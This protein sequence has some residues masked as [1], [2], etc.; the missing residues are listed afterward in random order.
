MKTIFYKR[1]VFVISAIIIAA[2]TRLL[3]HLP[4][5]TPVAAM[6]L[7]GGATLNDK[8][9]AFITPIIAMLVS[10]LL[11]ELVFGYGFHNTMLFV[12]AS[13]GLIT[14]LGTYLQNKIKFSS[15]AIASLASSLIFFLVTNFGI[16]T[17]A[18][19][20]E[21]LS[22]IY[23]LGV[24]FFH[25]SVIGDLFYTAILF[26]VYQIAVQRFPALVEIKK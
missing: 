7:L 19:Q 20:G 14:F 21:T 15:L 16:W 22:Y 17:V 6:A 5:F 8:R 11:L 4:N 12:Y 2:V 26:G 9:L 13:I 18:T 1:N 24:P 3:P 25:Y 23:A 10:D